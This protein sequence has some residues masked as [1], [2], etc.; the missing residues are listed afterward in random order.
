MEEYTLKLKDFCILL[1]LAVLWGTSFLFI[2]IASPVLGPMLLVNLRVLIAG[3]ALVIYATIY[4]HKINLLHKWKEYLLLGLLN[5]AIPFCLIAVA[6]LQINSSLASIIN[7]T[8]PLFAVLVARICKGEEITP[9]KFL[10][11]IFGVLGVSVLVGW[12]HQSMS[13]NFIFSVSLSILAA[14][15]LAIGGVYSSKKFTTDTSLD[16]AIGQQIAAGVLLLPITIIFTPNITNI[17]IEKNIILAIICL[18]IFCTALAYMLYFYLI[19]AVGSVK[20]L[21]VTFLVPIFGIIFGALLLNESISLRTILGVAI[22]L[23]GIIFV[24]DIKLKKS[25]NRV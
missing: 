13:N 11:L 6:E 20:T 21:S 8:T 18:A 16:L 4:K 22:I 7:S 1:L 14:L 2:K 5:A 24:T 9:K 23:L 3:V 17:A 19:H 10:G 15:F 25:Y 12:D